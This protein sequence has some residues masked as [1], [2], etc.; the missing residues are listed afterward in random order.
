VVNLLGPRSKT[1]SIGQSLSL[2]SSMS[3]VH[4]PKSVYLHGVRIMKAT[5]HHPAYITISPMH[6]SSNADSTALPAIVST[7]N[8]LF[9]CCFLWN[10]DRNF[11][12]HMNIPTSQSTC[13]AS[14]CSHV[15]SGGDSSGTI[16]FLRLSWDDEEA[17]VAVLWR[18]LRW[19]LRVGAHI[20]T[21]THRGPVTEG[22]AL[23]LLH[24][25]F[26]RFQG[27]VARERFC[28]VR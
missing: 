21:Y 16:S 14:G 12:F 23:G 26:G 8:S 28:L 27:L 4:Q 3:D 19:L 25:R 10:W 13:P 18:F 20:S 9:T 7:S 2:S 6:P 17:S 11:M 5:H 1:S 15:P 22:Q 24:P